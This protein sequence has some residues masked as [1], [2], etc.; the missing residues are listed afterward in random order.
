MKSLLLFIMFIL[1]PMILQGM[2]KKR[3]AREK[4]QRGQKREP[5]SERTA[6]RESGTGEPT[7][8]AWIDSVKAGAALDPE[9]EVFASTDPPP[10][11]TAFAPEI[12]DE[13]PWHPE[14]ERIE[15]EEPVDP[16]DLV[17]KTDLEP[18]VSVSTSKVRNLSEAPSARRA[19]RALREAGETGAKTRSRQ[20]AARIRLRRGDLRRAIVVNEILQRPLG[21]RETSEVII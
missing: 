13:T 16:E 8:K 14:P 18:L 1:L 11:A 19:R 12:D 3:R 15:P 21:E 20:G 7:L 10:I 6:T 2:E 17:P 5:K 4:G 9:P